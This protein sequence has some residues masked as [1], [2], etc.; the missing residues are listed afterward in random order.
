MFDLVNEC[1]VS[2]AKRNC[3]AKILHKESNLQSSSLLLMH[4]ESLPPL[5]LIK[6][7]V[8]IFVLISPLRWM[9]CYRRDN[10]AAS[11]PAAEPL[12]WISGNFNLVSAL[13]TKP[14]C[15]RIMATLATV[16]FPPGRIGAELTPCDSL[17][18]VI[19]RALISIRGHRAYFIRTMGRTT[20]WCFD[21]LTYWILLPVCS[22]SVEDPALISALNEGRTTCP[23]S[24]W[25]Q[26][27]KITPK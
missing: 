6:T 1:K 3:Y 4:R 13:F 7:C 9:S 22:T 18:A 10:G 24:V 16:N 20:G 19:S 12:L 5:D 17:G 8:H 27:I 2:H 26:R 14:D 23:C 15:S 11:H 21:S 25:A